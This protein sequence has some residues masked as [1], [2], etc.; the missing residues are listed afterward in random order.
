MKRY[1]V[2]LSLLVV[3][4][5]CTTTV[6]K[7]SIV[8]TKKIKPSRLSQCLITRGNETGD[9][10][11]SIIVVIPTRGG[12]HGPL[13]AVNNLIESVPGG[14]AAVDTQVRRT[15]FH[16]PFIYGYYGFEAKGKVLVDPVLR[17]LE[18]EKRNREGELKKPRS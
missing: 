4:G 14:V 9:D 15:W 12:D 11:Y 17:R 6:A 5:G 13:I 3:F 7:Y 8:S 16:I 2:L 18:E 1:L 10:S